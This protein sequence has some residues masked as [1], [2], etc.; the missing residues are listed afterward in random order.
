MGSWDSNRIDH[1]MSMISWGIISRH[2]EKK[3]CLNPRH[4]TGGSQSGNH[5][6]IQTGSPREELAFPAH[7]MRSWPH[8]GTSHIKHFLAFICLL[9]LTLP[10]LLPATLLL[11]WISQRQ[12]IV[13]GWNRKLASY[14]PWNLGYDHGLTIL[15]LKW[16]C[17]IEIAL[18]SRR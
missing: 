13:V 6:E 17:C 12:L 18:R 9:P 8:D 15:I 16:D 5:W 11:N 10:L 2:L 3:H 14:K 4:V 7:R 1:W